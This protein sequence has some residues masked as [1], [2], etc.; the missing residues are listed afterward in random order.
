MNDPACCSRQI[1]ELARCSGVPEPYLARITL[2]LA[3]RGFLITKRGRTGGLTLGRASA[4][5]SLLQIVEAVEDKKWIADCLFN[6]EECVSQPHCPTQKLWQRIRRELTEELARIT[7]A[8]MLG[9]G[10]IV[11][12]QL[13]TKGSPPW[14]R[15][16]CGTEPHSAIPNPPRSQPCHPIAG[17]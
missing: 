6:L 9:P 11:M 8:D 13:L 5:I 16:A 4:E 12:K 3:R 1:A 14:W 17:G 7:L 10:K 15:P 2:I